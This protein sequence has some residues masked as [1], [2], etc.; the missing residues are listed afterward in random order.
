MVPERDSKSSAVT[1][2]SHGRRALNRPDGSIQQARLSIVLSIFCLLPPESI[3]YILYAGIKG[4]EANTTE[5]GFHWT[6]LTYLTELGRSRGYLHFLMGSRA[7]LGACYVPV[8]CVIRFRTSRP[9]L[10]ELLE[11]P[12]GLDSTE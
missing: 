5:S 4:W 3:L 6:D 10:A 1:V 11:Q 2:A 8:F 7:S 12:S 9:D